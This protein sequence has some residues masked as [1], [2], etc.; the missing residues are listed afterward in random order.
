MGVDGVQDTL[1]PNMAPWHVEYFKMKEFEK[2]G[3]SKKVSL[4]FPTLL[5]FSLEAGH[6]PLM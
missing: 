1:P 4:T 2:N 3:R 6:K 5:P